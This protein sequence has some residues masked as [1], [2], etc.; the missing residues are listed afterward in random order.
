ME[1]CKDKTIII[2]NCLVTE[3]NCGGTTVLQYIIYR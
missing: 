3:D 2:W 1:F